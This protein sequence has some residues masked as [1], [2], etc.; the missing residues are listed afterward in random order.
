MLSARG[1]QGVQV[2]IEGPEEVHDALRGRGSFAASLRGIA[3]LL[4]EGIEVTMNATLSSENADGFMDLVALASAAGV[5]RLGFSRL[6][7]SGRGAGMSAAM[8]DAEKVRTLYAEIRG[9]ALDHLTLVSG[10][11]IYSQLSSSADSLA[12]SSA[13]PSDNSDE[14]DP[15][16][17]ASGG[18]AAG[19]SGLTILAD[20]TVVP[21]R[22]LP[23]PIGNLRHDALRELWATSPVLEKLRDRSAYRG[24]CGTCSRWAS[25]RGCRAIAYAHTERRNPGQAGDDQLR[26]LV[27]DDPQCFIACSPS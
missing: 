1:V 4:D 10:D 16:A 24:K 23:V 17:T 8:L 3:H 19:L 13:S 21:C 20:G 25:C 5:Q 2:S 9:L 22:R 6:V 12:N 14:Q 27:A 11:P 15:V 18:C 7:P 26:G